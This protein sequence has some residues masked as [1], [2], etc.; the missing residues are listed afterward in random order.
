MTMLA[1]SARPARRGFTLI[2]L[3]VVIAI[4]GILTGLLLS[5]V[6]KARAAAARVSCMNNLKQI[7]LACHLY[8]DGMLCFPPGYTASS[9]TAQTPAG[10]VVSNTTPGWGWGTYLLPYI[11]QNDL[12]AQFNLTQPCQN[13][14]GIQT[15]IKVYLCPSDQAPPAGFTVPGAGVQA[16]PC[17]YAAIDG[18]VSNDTT[19]DAGGSGVFYCNS[20]VS[21]AEISDGTSNT[22]MVG[23]RAWCIVMGVWA[24]A[25][26]GGTCNPGPQSPYM[27][28]NPGSTKPGQGAGDLVLMHASGNNAIFSTGGR[29]L[30]DPCSMHVNGSN[31]V[32]ADGS[33]H[34]MPNITTAPGT[35]YFGYLG[36]IAG[37]EVI[38]GAFV[39]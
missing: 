32:F 30:D 18:G 14:P 31:F 13:Y 1:S 26:N 6:Q 25:I 5:A 3:L 2:E 28:A 33:V 35:T 34:F 10:T 24:G 12:F 22:V 23:E 8:H 37:G 7:G 20:Q 39:P 38:P 15:T 19:A 11:E 4:M 29:G 21:I 9:V 36:T 27:I 17:S 16:G